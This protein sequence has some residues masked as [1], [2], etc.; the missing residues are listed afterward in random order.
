MVNTLKGKTVWNN[1]KGIK[2]GIN[3]VTLDLNP[4]RKTRKS[5]LTFLI[6]FCSII[7]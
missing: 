3:Q 6:S 5:C 2:F 7:Q 1:E 4:T